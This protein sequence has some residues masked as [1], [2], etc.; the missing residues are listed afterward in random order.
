MRLVTQTDCLANHFSGEETIRILAQAGFDAIDWSFFEMLDGSG[1]WCQDDWEDYAR[2]MKEEAARQGIGFSQAHAPFPSSRGTEP[3]DTQIRQR[4]ERSIRASAAMGVQNIV[5]HPLQHLP[6]AKNREWLF[7]QNVAFYRSLIPLCEE[8]NIRVC[9]EN[10]WQRDPKR[11]YIVD[12]VCA[13]PEEFCALLDTVDSPW[14]AACLDVG[15][16]ALV[17]LDPADVIRALGPKR[18]GALHI[19]DVDYLRD[20]HTM[21]FVQKLDWESIC[22]ALGEIGYNGDL[23]LESD[24]FLYPFPKALMPD[25]SRLMAQTGRYLI[26]R[27]EAYRN[28]QNG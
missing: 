22:R 5:V 26:S 3:F 21:P 7:E 14:I 6:Y 16:C 11:G 17:G 8:L 2:R 15:H 28:G 4:I 9:C 12:S 18:L 27:V 23:T 1:P 20:C 10:M 24:Q 25:A 13:Q 19:H